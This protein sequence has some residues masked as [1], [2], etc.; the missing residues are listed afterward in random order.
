MRLV[1]RLWYQ[2]NWCMPLY[3]RLLPPPKKSWCALRV[4]EC[5]T[6]LPE[7]NIWWS[8]LRGLEH[9][10]A[11]PD[12]VYI[13]SFPKAGTHMLLVLVSEILAC[14]RPDREARLAYS[15]SGAPGHYPHFLEFGH[16]QLKQRD[17]E[18]PNPRL[19]V[20]HLPLRLF[21]ADAL[22]RCEQRAARLGHADSMLMRM[23]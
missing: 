4:T 13:V 17:A 10:E 7:Q 21:P 12:D 11:K 6:V 5:G 2:T 16:P 8:T 14:R 9:W 23:S 20:T 1:Q 22:K 19:F 18:Q 15:R 3:Y